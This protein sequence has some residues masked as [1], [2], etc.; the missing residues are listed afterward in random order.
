MIQLED[1]ESV[2]RDHLES[3]P[4]QPKGPNDDQDTT[5]HHTNSHAMTTENPHQTSNI[6]IKIVDLGVGMSRADLHIPKAECRG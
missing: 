3:L 5:A 6:N 1:A 2:V 4:Y